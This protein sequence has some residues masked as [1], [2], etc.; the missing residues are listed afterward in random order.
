MSVKRL[1]RLQGRTVALANTLQEAAD[2]DDHRR[3]RE[4]VL[5]AASVL[6][7]ANARMQEA[8]LLLRGPMQQADDAEPYPMTDT[9]GHHE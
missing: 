9:G 6:D 8:I 1:Q 7:I 2:E 3:V 4:H 5:A